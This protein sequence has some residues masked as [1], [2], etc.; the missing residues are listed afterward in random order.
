MVDQPQRDFKQKKRLCFLQTRNITTPFFSLHSFFSA[1]DMTYSKPFE[2]FIRLSSQLS[3]HQLQQNWASF[4][5]AR[6]SRESLFRSL[7]EEP[8]QLE[9]LCLYLYHT[10]WNSTLYEWT[11]DEVSIV[12][13]ISRI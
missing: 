8:S 13:Y 6:I 5:F 3:T 10:G 2:L 12:P 9:D 11:S 4:V 1:L 7:S